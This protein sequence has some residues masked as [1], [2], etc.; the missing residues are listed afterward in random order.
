MELKKVDKTLIEVNQEDIRAAVQDWLR[1]KTGF[2]IPPDSD[3]KWT[4]M[5][6][7]DLKIAISWERIEEK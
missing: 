7:Q 5:K 4:G 3:W 2:T 6:K 1:N